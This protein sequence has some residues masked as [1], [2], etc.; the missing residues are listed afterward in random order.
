[1]GVGGESGLL[2]NDASMT[3]T[4]A[5]NAVYD[6]LRAEFGDASPKA[7]G[8]LSERSFFQE[9]ALVLEAVG[10]AP[11]TILDVGCGGGLVALPL[12]EAGRRV[13]GVDFSAGACRRAKSNGIEAI[14]GDAFDLP[15][16]EGMADV[17][18]NVEFVQEHRPEA[19]ERLLQE[20]A[21]VLRPG[22]RLVLVWSNRKALPHRIAGPLLRLLGRLRGRPWLT[23]AVRYTMHSVAEVRA[24]SARAGL[25]VDE[26]FAIF[27]PWRA[28]LAR[29]DGVLAASIGSSFVATFRKSR[30]AP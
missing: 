29:A 20:V 2:A 5:K 7:H 6:E 4:D 12:V 14:R 24:A 16:A 22:G 23:A 18:L 3:P 9:R 8:Y 30:A 26:V 28:R 19:V 13:V 21:R 10:D 25:A 15:L 11:G 27:P 17:V 1:M